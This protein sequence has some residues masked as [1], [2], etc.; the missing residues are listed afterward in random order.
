MVLITVVVPAIAI[1]V[2]PVAAWAKVLVNW[3]ELPAPAETIPEFGD[4]RL[5]IRIIAR[6]T[7]DI[8]LLLQ[9]PGVEQ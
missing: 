4:A 7:A 6:F 5:A 3:T 8:Q 2:V 9:F 1:W